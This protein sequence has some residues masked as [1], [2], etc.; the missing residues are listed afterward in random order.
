MGWSSHAAIGAWGSVEHI[1][2]V[3]YPLPH[4]LHKKLCRRQQALTTGIW[5]KLHVGE[6]AAKAVRHDPKR[7]LANAM[8]SAQTIVEYHLAFIHFMPAVWALQVLFQWERTVSNEDVKGQDLRSR[9]C[10]GLRR[11]GC[12]LPPNPAVSVA[13]VLADDSVDEFQIGVHDRHQHHAEAPFVVT[14]QTS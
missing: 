4:F 5:E 13:P 3:M 12:F 14:K 9:Q 10:G 6:E 11:T 8:S 7:V 2:S 1:A